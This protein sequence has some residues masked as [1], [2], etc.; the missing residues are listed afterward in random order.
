MVFTR[1]ER[2]LGRRG[3]RSPGAV[4]NPAGETLSRFL[5]CGLAPIHRMPSQPQGSCP[6]NLPPTPLRIS[7]LHSTPHSCERL[8]WSEAS[9]ARC[10]VAW[11]SFHH[12]SH[13]MTSHLESLPVELFDCVAHHLRLPAHQSLRLSSR[14]LHQLIHA[15]FVHQAFSEQSTTLGP[16]SL[17]RLVHV[18]RHHHL[19]DAVKVLHITLLNQD[20]YANLNAIKRVGRFPP[21]KRFP[22]VLGIKDKH[23]NDEA[24]TLSYVMKNE[25]PARLYDG[26][27]KALRGLPRLR[28]IFFSAK[29]SAPSVWGP[30]AAADH[31]FRTRCFEALIYAITHSNIK[32][33][34]FGMARRKRHNTSY[35]QADLSFLAFQLDAHSFEAL[36]RCFFDLQSLK[37]SAIS[38]Y[39]TPRSDAWFKGIC[40]F[41]MAAPRLRK[42]SLSL[43][44][45]D[46][47]SPFS[48]KVVSSLA[49]ICRLPELETFELVNCT[50]HGKDVAD[51]IRAHSSSLRHVA[52]SDICLVV[53][54]AHFTWN[55]LK[56]CRALKT[57]RLVAIKDSSAPQSLA[58][59]Q[60]RPQMTWDGRKHMNLSDW[61]RGLIDSGKL[62][63]DFPVNGS[64]T[65]D[66][67]HG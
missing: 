27:L 43:D 66:G 38:G 47:L 24:T 22:R 50:C 19:R 7:A 8:C 17:D 21:P 1:R 65:Y 10:P 37:L 23:V 16:S 12:S 34:E 46:H 57:L 59:F 20:E 63:A 2:S 52:F 29:T 41:I 33:E 4:V 67:I 13:A 18:S 55:A 39:G 3:G 26:L 28:S 35:K 51:L 56:D 44:R 40:A 5:A 62:P 31:L 6:A 60:D 42:L 49:S 11:Q 30:N 48:S 14:R 61:L 58:R 32:L 54:T 25:R 64:T 53:S 15:T 45:H 36:R 9:I